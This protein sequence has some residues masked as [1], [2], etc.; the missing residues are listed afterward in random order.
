MKDCVKC[1]AQMEDNAVFC[2]VCGKRL[3]K[4]EHKKMNKVVKILLLCVLYV[5]ILAI[6]IFMG[7]MIGS[8]GKKT[9]AEVDVSSDKVVEGK[10]EKS[11]E[12]EVSDGIKTENSTEVEETKEDVTDEEKNKNAD[13]LGDEEDKET[14]KPDVINASD[15]AGGYNY[16][17]IGNEVR[18]KE[19]IL[20]AAYPEINSLK[21]YEDNHDGMY[22]DRQ[23]LEINTGHYVVRFLKEYP[24][25]IRIVYARGDGDPLVRI[26][27]SKYL[28]DVK[29]FTVEEELDR[30]YYSLEYGN[31]I[32]I[33]D[34]FLQTLDGGIYTFKT[35]QEGAISHG[36][37]FDLVV[38]E[39]GEK[40]DN[41]K[42]AIYS[43]TQY[44]SPNSKN[45]VMFY[46][47][48]T[49]SRIA[50]VVVDYEALSDEDYELIYDG[51]G[52]VFHPEFLEKH[53]DNPCLTLLFKL[54]N[55]KK[56]ECK[57]GFLN[58]A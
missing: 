40:V 25:D 37:I 47:M 52:V 56:L 46:V 33:S 27:Y 13:S 4:K 1:G 11:E 8:N 55:G 15:N 23:E 31:V 30:K 12:L 41:F 51:Y 24:R 10:T 35:L 22:S 54:E 58:H 19:G 21:I 28:D 50:A 57:I 39:K 20:A 6:G 34:E 36:W 18:E 32:N 2:N 3:I 42:P 7:R 17:F 43:S 44:Y 29:A 9:V 53:K 5:A 49:P 14:S 26:T 38:H 48:N 45:D 16:V